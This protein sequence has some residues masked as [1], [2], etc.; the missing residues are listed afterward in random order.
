MKR[1]HF[2]PVLLFI[3]LQ[4][5]LIFAQQ[6]PDTLWIKVTF[7]DF[8]ADGSNPE[9][10]P[11]HNGGLTIGMVADTLT[12]DRK[13]VLGANPFFNYYIDKWFRPYTPGDNTIPDYTDRSGTY[14]GLLT[15]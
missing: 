7:Y 10:E 2:I 12:A 4:A 6:F 14:G 5:C 15:L 1:G 9:F 13:P 3:L 8:H 11:D